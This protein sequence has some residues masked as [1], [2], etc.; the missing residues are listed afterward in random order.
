MGLGAHLVVVLELQRAS[1]E[2]EHVTLL[3]IHKHGGGH[4]R[5]GVGQPHEDGAKLGAGLTLIPEANTH[6]SA[7][8]LYTSHCMPAHANR[9]TLHSPA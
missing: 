6:P 8:H 3:H 9:L 2:L 1:L 4:K 7:A 5:Q